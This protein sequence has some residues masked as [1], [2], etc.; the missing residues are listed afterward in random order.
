METQENEILD[1]PEKEAQKSSLFKFR[2]SATF[3]MAA[4]LLFRLMHW[5][6]GMWLLAAGLSM[7]VFW[8]FLDLYSRK[9]HQL[10]HISYFIGRLLLVMALI[11]LYMHELELMRYGI[12]AAAMAFSVGFVLSPRRLRPQN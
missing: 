10:W 11:M 6:F 3:I 4:G 12:F 8:N 5:P 9:D 2:I 7:W 1:L